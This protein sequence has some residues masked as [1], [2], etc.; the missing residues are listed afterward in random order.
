MRNYT[1]MIEAKAFR[2]FIRI[3]PVFRSER[4]STN[5]KL[6]LHKALIRSAMNYAW[7]FATSRKVAGS[8]SDGVNFFFNV[9]NPSS[10]TRLCGFSASNRSE[11]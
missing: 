5:I 8:R 6:T 7:E 11:Y 10:R 3:Y 2:T 1:E 9:F 4:L